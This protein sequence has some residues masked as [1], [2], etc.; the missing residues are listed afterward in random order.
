MASAEEGVSVSASN[1]EH[2]PRVGKGHQYKLMKWT[3]V[4]CVSLLWGVTLGKDV[5]CLFC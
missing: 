4:L 1:G 2:G 3:T 5:L